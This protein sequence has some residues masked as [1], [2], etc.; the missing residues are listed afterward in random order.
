MA[1]NFEKGFIAGRVK[2]KILDNT[3]KIFSLLGIFL[4]LP[5]LARDNWCLTD[6]NIIFFIGV[7][8]V[9]ITYIF[10]KNIFINLKI[11]TVFFLALCILF[12]GLYSKGIF[13]PTPIFIVA[14]SVLLSFFLD[15]KRAYYAIFIYMVVYVFFAYLFINKYLVYT[16]H[17]EEFE[18]NANMWAIRGI[19]LFL[20][21]VA[22]INISGY[23]NKLILN[24]FRII[25]SKNAE[26]NEYRENL[27]NL[28]IDR[29]KELE[30]SLMREKELGILKTNFI[31]MASHEFRTPL[32]SI[33]GLTELVLNY[34][35]RLTIEQIK[36]RLKKINVE[37][38]NM[39]NML[40]DVLIIGQVDSD[41]IVFTPIELN[42]VEFVKEIIYEYQLFKIAKREV[43]FR[44]VSDE[45]V[46]NVDI[47]LMKQIVLNLFSNAL[48]Y[49]E[50]P[51]PILIS[52][53]KENDSVIFSVTD[54]GI[55]ISKKEQK[56]IFE[57][58]F[59]ANNVENIPGTGLGLTI[60]E[61]AVNMHNGKIEVLSELGKGTTFRIVLPC[62]N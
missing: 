27:E 58:F 9:V 35:D 43:D 57:P 28:V 49:S 2:E 4:I 44:F 36:E 33:Q 24:N 22:L 32:T 62:N 41:K 19:V 15:K 50:F 53:L 30:Q 52:F 10:K 18:L 55:G 39:T 46:C 34:F 48:K 56:L 25:E 21:S 59:R 40:E 7:I 20:I 14:N 45:I 5:V 51:K 13:S 61:R 37:V 17:I 47:K 3:L 38:T 23:Y 1:D 29:T 60:I 11:F 12:Q 26:L 6:K 54:Q 8:V 31:S 42:L 16:S